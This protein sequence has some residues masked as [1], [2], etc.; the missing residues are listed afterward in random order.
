MADLTIEDH[1]VGTGAEARPG[2]TVT[3]HYVGTLDDGSKFDSSRDR[4]KAFSFPLGRGQVIEGW[5]QGVAGMR[6]GG[7]R[8]LVIPA[9]LGYGDQGAPPVIPPGATLH[10][11]IELLEVR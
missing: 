3:V 10:F 8:R 2:G 1:T 4:G 11:D 7:V 9:E 5:D 6:V